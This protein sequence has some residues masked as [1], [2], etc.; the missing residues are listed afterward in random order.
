MAIPSLFPISAVSGPWLVHLNFRA[1]SD[2]TLAGL[3]WW[4]IPG[5]AIPWVVKDIIAFPYVWRA[6]DSSEESRH[7]LL[8]AEGVV[9]RPLNHSG[10]IWIRGELWRAE[11]AGGGSIPQGE[12]VR[13]Q[14]VHGLTLIVQPAAPHPDRRE[15]RRPETD[16]AERN[17]A[18]SLR[19]DRMGPIFNQ[20]SG[21]GRSRYRKSK[22]RELKKK[23]SQF[24]GRRGHLRRLPS[25]HFFQPLRKQGYSDP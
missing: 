1:H 14:N 25:A 8:G 23:G 4:V 13:V 6:Y 24:P 20:A 16:V 22:H 18:S 15:E 3:P 2:S 21:E 10:Y 19:M 11:A 7:P 12:T 9:V 5:V 17:E